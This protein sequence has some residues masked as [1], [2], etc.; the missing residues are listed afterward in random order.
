LWDGTILILVLVVGRVVSTDIKTQSCFEALNN[1]AVALVVDLLQSV[2]G[3]VVI[4]S[5][6]VI[7]PQLTMLGQNRVKVLTFNIGHL[8]KPSI[9]ALIYGLNRH[10][11]R[12]VVSS[13]I[14]VKMNW[15]NKWS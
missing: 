7:N 14:A 15:K 5:F 10:Y 4:D 13:L 1:R 8:Q 12:I 2:K 9:Q 6:S 11:Y 3:K